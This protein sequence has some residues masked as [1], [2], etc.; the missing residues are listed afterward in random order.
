M[1]AHHDI[2]I[3]AADP[4]LVPLARYWGQN[5]PRVEWLARRMGIDAIDP[6]KD[7]FPA[8]TMFFA[9][10]LALEPLLNIALNLDDFEPEEGQRD[11]TMAHAIERV[12]AY[13][14]RAAGLTVT[15]AR[16]TDLESEQV[17][18]RVG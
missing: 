9:R 15:S 14:A 8:G 12:I 1:R 10:A 3:A 2:G 16:T 6:V 13:S 4:Y 11:G 17:L 18:V 7:V 5:Q